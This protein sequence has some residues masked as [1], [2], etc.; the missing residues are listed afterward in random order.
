MIT[1][2]LMCA[3]LVVA[4]WWDLLTAEVSSVYTSGPCLSSTTCP[5]QEELLIKLAMVMKV[6][7]NLNPN[8]T[9]SVGAAGLFQITKLATID[10]AIF[11]SIPLIGNPYD[12]AFN[13]RIGTCYL[14]KLYSDTQD[15]TEALIIYNG[16]YKTLKRYRKGLNINTETANYVLK[17]NRICK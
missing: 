2:T 1:K 14:A 9:S 5:S 16:G 8:A 11:C 3:Y 7:S 12:P 6:E 13:T 10:A 17:V 15:W 4:P